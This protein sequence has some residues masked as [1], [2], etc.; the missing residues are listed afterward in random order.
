MYSKIRAHD[1][2]KIRFINSVL[3]LFFLAP[4]LH[5]NPFNGIVASGGVSISPSGS[6]LTI[7]QSSSTAIINWN[8]F[9]I[10]NGESTVFEFNGAAGAN[11][12]VLNL[13]SAGNGGS[14]IAGSLSSTVGH[15]GP[16]GGTVMLLNPEGVLFTST[17]TVNVGSL[18]ASTLGLP[19]QNDFL[20][21]TALHFSGTS[22]AGIQNQAK[23]LNALGDVFLIAHTVQNSG[24]ISAG[25]EAG[26]AAGNTVTLA[27]SGSERLTVVAGT[28][29]GTP[30]G[31]NNTEAGKINAVVTELKAAGGNIYAL[32][33]NNAGLVRATSLV[34][35][36]G[37]IFFRATDSSTGNQAGV[38]STGTINV[39]GANVTAADVTMQGSQVA[40]GGT[41]NAG[42]GAVT[43]TTTSASGVNGT[44]DIDVSG[45]AKITAGSVSLHSGTDA[46]GDISFGGGVKIQ[47]DTQSYQAGIGDGSGST[48]A[49]D[50]TDNSPT[51]LNQSGNGSPASF[52]FE[53]DAMIADANIPAS[54]QFSL[55]TPPANYTIQSD[56]G[57]VTLNTGANVAGSALTLDADGTLTIGGNLN[58]NS[59][60]ASGNTI[61]LNGSGGS[62]TVTTTGAQTYN[63]DV[64]LGA[65]TTL[66]GTM[67]TF[68]KT[69]AAS[70]S[71]F[72]FP[73]GRIISFTPELTLNNSGTATFN[74]AVNILG[75]L[76]AS[77]NGN[78]VVNDTISAGTVN[79]SEATA[80]NG[81]LVT[82]GGSQ[83]YNGAVT[84]G[85]DTTLNA[86]TTVLIVTA[87]GGAIITDSTVLGNISLLQTVNGAQS[88]TLNAAGTTTF[89]GAVGNIQPLTSLT[90]DA[91]GTTALN[92]GPV[93]ATAVDFKDDVTLGA[94]TTINELAPNGT[95][96]IFEKTV[97]ADSAANNRAL[98]V[99]F[100]TA[101]GTTFGGAVG[102]NQSLASLT[103]YS[104]GGTISLNGGSVTTSGA[105]SY[106]GNV[107]LGANTTL[108]G[109]TLDLFGAL[110]GGGNNLTL[111]NSG[112]ATLG[113]SLSGVNALAA[114]GSGSL[115][116]LNT[117]SAATVNDSEATAFNSGGTVTT[118]GKQ[119]YNGALTLGV[120]TTLASS[121]AG[122]NGNISF[123]TVDG[124]QALTVNTAGTTTFGGAVGN[125]QAL[126]SLTTDAAGTT[127]LNGGT[128]TTTGGQAYN[129]NVTLG[130][131]TTVNG[132]TLNL[133]GALSG[134]GNNLTL[135]NSGAA[136][137]GGALS[138]VNAL[139][140][141]GSGN[142]AANNTISSGSLND[143]EATALNGGTVTTVGAQTYNQNMTLGAAT[144][145]T[146]SG[147]GNITFAN[148][149]NGAQSLTVNTAG[150]TIF[151]G[152]VGNNQALNSLTTD[153]AGTTALNGGSVTAL[154]ADFK[155]DVILGANTIIDGTTMIIGGMTVGVSGTMT[156][157]R[158][159]NADS[160]ANNR[161]LTIGTPVSFGMKT[162]FGGAVGNN[163]AL[164][165]LTTFS[166]GGNTAINGGSVTTVDGQSY[167]NTVIFG[168]NTTLN[169]TTL[170]FFGGYTM[171]VGNGNN[172]T[173]NN[174]EGAILFGTTS[175]INTLTANGSGNLGIYNTI[176]ASSVIDSEATTFF[177][178]GGT[179]TT[180][181]AQNYNDVVTLGENTT[182]TSSGGGNITFAKAVDGAQSLAVNTSGNEIFN[183]VVGGNT[184][185]T[186]L[187]TDGSGTVGGKAQ[188]NGGSVTTTGG[189]TYNDN[190]T[191]GAATTLTSSGG[192]N[193]TFG[194]AVDGAQTLAVNT[195]GNEIFNGAVG[196]NTPLKSLTT[197]GSGTVGGSAQLN[198]GSV[199]TTGGQTYNDNVTLGANTTL[200][201]TTLNLNG[202]LTGNGN[203][204]TLN[205]IGT[206]TLQSVSGV[207]ALVAD[208]SGNL[209]AD[210]SISSATINDSEPT[211]LNGRSVATTGTQTYGN[212][213]T[214]GANT[215]L[216]LSG[217]NFTGIGAISGNG[218]PLIVNG[219][220]YSVVGEDE[221]LKRSLLGAILPTYHPIEVRGRKPWQRKRS[222]IPPWSITDPMNSLQVPFD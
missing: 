113:A 17:A 162:T 15:L 2:K 179:V 136:T 70:Q 201:G 142:L 62:E 127:A 55:N 137:L 11:S 128:V 206:A 44:G 166:F 215:T 57:N 53:Q 176:S 163:Q 144:T 213:V 1:M 4:C 169:G 165:S 190:V 5:A 56:G 202:A 9:N 79:D 218:H 36:N 121:G 197:D 138:G 118:T 112:L 61:A 203:N 110:A 78:L 185:L 200:N 43:V 154:N 145:L 132:T 216:I 54:S 194:Q 120:D 104:P 83:T 103:A 219:V 143:G 40:L 119:T 147:G 108:N 106:F 26:L 49:V 76:T 196:G 101:G 184:P 77:G 122:A 178:S 141:S 199:T 46:T 149:V 130:A 158:T 51:F 28:G 125:N 124:A 181:G 168:A 210:G 161:T 13:V 80:L 32:A 24:T 6:L 14:T 170:I 157:E 95:T 180:T 88:L 156:F 93:N 115:S 81:G 50:L 117:I 192:A 189:Q 135:N 99:G 107:T 114:A 134:G 212:I 182:L 209:V 150:T 198:G 47:A 66:N 73:G 34:K 29:T 74:G 38:N 92:G 175:G 222:G 100:L 10:A 186:S 208:G 140:A 69:V 129:D 217:L 177:G 37:H 52:T 191:L 188:L 87:P 94:N 126:T 123:Q 159:V 89:G 3:V 183:G 16:I 67:M 58:L 204:L 105:Q 195:S 19:D 116:V 64:T 97:N 133:N 211:L 7:S 111:N 214:L 20:N 33:I 193:I 205:N 72:T 22:T 171:I 109:T 146:S 167:N 152:V 153:S 148:A 45:E 59:L 31:V 155:D 42:A 35:Q 221:T 65:N 23:N 187:T 39:D 18:V 174:S 173:L 8:T 82:T 48:A 71:T 151:D 63:D 84:L 139:T 68:E 102:N 220:V 96:T 207:N 131:N 25:N 21:G 90:T 160:A 12:A 98:S 172:L 164:A 91:A 75:T 27:Q 85:A 41:V 30:F 86:L 60:S